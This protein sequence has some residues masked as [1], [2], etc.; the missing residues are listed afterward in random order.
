MTHAKWASPFALLSAIVTL[1]ASVT[2]AILFR[3]SDE[4]E[5]SRQEFGFEHTFVNWATLA[6]AIPL[7]MFTFGGHSL[8]RSFASLSA[9]YLRPFLPFDQAFLPLIAS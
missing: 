3:L 2:V 6:D 4:Y 1:I 7:F 9:E 8:V 5:T